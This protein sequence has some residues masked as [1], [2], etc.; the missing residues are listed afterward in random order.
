MREWVALCEAPSFCVL[1][2]HATQTFSLCAVVLTQVKALGLVRAFDP[3]QPFLNQWLQGWCIIGTG[4]YDSAATLCASKE[5]VPS[6]GT[7][8]LKDTQ[9]FN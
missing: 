6:D 3:P 2:H 4:L 5:R 9:H 7:R 8:A 1:S